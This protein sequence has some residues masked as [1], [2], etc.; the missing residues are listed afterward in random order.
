MALYS[1]TR[2]WVSRPRRPGDVGPNPYSP[3]SAHYAERHRETETALPGGMVRVDI[4][5]PLK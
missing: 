2:G 3:E 4:G 5:E 1:R